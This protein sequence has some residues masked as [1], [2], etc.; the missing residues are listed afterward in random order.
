MPPVS[1][2]GGEG[3]WSGTRPPPPRRRR[4]PASFS[5]VGGISLSGSGSDQPLCSLAITY[6]HDVIAV[7]LDT[8]FFCS[9]SKRYTTKKHEDQIVEDQMSFARYSHSF[10]KDPVSLL[11]ASSIISSSHKIM[12]RPTSS[13]SNWAFFLGSWLRVDH[14]L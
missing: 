11:V 7:V 3:S 14:Q 9:S 12:Q 5:L 10:M 6:R 1:G 4:R 8:M 13:A 2:T